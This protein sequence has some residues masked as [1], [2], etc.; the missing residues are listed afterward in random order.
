[1]RERVSARATQIPSYS[2]LNAMSDVSDS[3]KL[4]I[5]FYEMREIHSTTAKKIM[6]ILTAWEK[7][8]SSAPIDV[9]SIHIYL[10]QFGQKLMKNALT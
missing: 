6:N 7:L 10:I 2:Q 5:F 1:M 8:P 9:I 4:K 3:D